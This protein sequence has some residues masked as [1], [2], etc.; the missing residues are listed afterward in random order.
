MRTAV[1]FVL[2]LKA[3]LLIAQDSVR[4][5]KFEIRGYAKDLQTLT[6]NKDL[7]E[8]I[9]GNF[10]HN[11]LNFKYKPVAGFTA[12]LEMRNRIFW[13]EEVRIAPG[14]SSGL[15]YPS[16]S[17][18][19]SHTW[20]E[21]EG[22]L[23]H[24]NID[25]LWME[26]SAA[27][28]SVRVGRQRIN[29]GIG[30]AWNPNDLFNTFNFLDFDYE[31]RPA[32]DAVKVQ[33]RMGTMSNLELAVARTGAETENVIAAGRYFTN[34]WNYDFQFLAGWY[35]NQ[36][37]A[38]AGWSG[39]IGNTGF[40]GEL[41]YFFDRG[42]WP[43]QLNILVEADHIFNNGW[44]VRAGALLNN[45]GLDKPISFLDVSSLDLSPRNPMPTKWN[46]LT[47][48]AKEITPLFTANAGFVYAPQTNL[49]ILLPSLQYNL[50]TNLDVSLVWQSFFAEL[51]V[52]FEVLSHRIFLRFKWSF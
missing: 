36:P 3:T 43:S 1:I 15:R 5:K 44:Y 29:W 37:T 14:L 2:V 49:L 48:V 45:R 46:L 4:V 16:E 10:I 25:R 50:A 12:A 32:S 52:G 47:T 30:T 26:Y 51:P 38:G 18:D 17:V 13:G 11:R 21:T 6:F 7:S 35:M 9:S 23:F 40:K 39:S 20:F 42:E 34:R 8:L 22:M 19:L 33:Y 31:E 28:W 41:Q 24:S 27:Q